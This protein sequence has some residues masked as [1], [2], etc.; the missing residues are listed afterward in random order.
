LKNICFSSL[1]QRLLLQDRRKIK[2]TNCKYTN[3]NKNSGYLQLKK[4]AEI[5]ITNAGRIDYF[6]RLAF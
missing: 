6:E 1:A 4:T 5:K 2:I 3:K